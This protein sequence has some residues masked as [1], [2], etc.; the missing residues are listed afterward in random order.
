MQGILI[1]IGGNED[2]GLGENE[3][4]T[5][6]FI[7]K[8]I[9]ANVVKE[10]GGTDAKIVVI[11]TASSIPQEVGENYKAA[12]N[13]LACKYVTIL[14]IREREKSEETEILQLIK[15]AD[16]VLFSW[17]RPVQDSRFYWWY[18]FTYIAAPK[19]G[20]LKICVGWH[21]CRSDV[22][23][24]RNDQRRSCFRCFV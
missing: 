21:Q 24:Q 10:S 15:E 12:F 13:K 14:D 19:T 4:Y 3:M 18:K 9:L 16:C 20:N 5:L 6:E 22:H 7:G 11:T 8:G 2:K 17:R 1:P 23:E